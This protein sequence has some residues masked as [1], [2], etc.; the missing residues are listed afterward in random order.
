MRTIEEELDAQEEAIQS[1]RDYIYVLE[2]E[3]AQA[4][5]YIN[6]LKGELSILYNQIDSSR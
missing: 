6:N 5:Y 4:K 2:D 1:L 3:L